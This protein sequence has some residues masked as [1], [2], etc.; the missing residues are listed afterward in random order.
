MPSKERAISLIVSVASRTRSACWP[1]AMAS[2]P[3]VC[4][5]SWADSE[6]VRAVMLMPVTSSRSC[7]TAKLTESAMAPVMSSVTVART[8]RS[9]SA[10][11]LISSSRRMMACWFF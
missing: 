2:W 3:V 1:E 6:T 5:V 8:V 7:S 11:E 4:M 9:P 10:S